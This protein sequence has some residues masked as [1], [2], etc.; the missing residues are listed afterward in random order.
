MTDDPRQIRRALIALAQ[1]IIR[2]EEPVCRSLLLE[3]A[4]LL[5]N[6][7]DDLIDQLARE[8]TVPPEGRAY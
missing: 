2:A 6:A 7:Y 5:A 4:Q 8:R 1:D 3:A